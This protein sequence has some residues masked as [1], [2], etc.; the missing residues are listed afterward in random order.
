M[1]I[2]LAFGIP[3]LAPPLSMGIML[4]SCIARFLVPR[5]YR[6]RNDGLHRTHPFGNWLLD[7]SA[8][9]TAAETQHARFDRPWPA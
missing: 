1:R 2:F 6:L 7:R 9:E 3:T 5:L 4:A 8:P